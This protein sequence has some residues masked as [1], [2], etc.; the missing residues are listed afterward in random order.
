[1]NTL[2]LPISR[3]LSDK[4]RASAYPIVKH[5]NVIDQ[6]KPV[7]QTSEM[8]ERYAH[9]AAEHL[10]P[11]AQSFTKRGAFWYTV[12]YGRKNGLRF[13]NVTR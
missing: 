6:V 13:V 4:C 9:F 8:V 7:F 5:L 12:I 10:S 1:M 3:V 2:P 11:W